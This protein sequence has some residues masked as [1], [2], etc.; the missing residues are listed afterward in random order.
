MKHTVYGYRTGNLTSAAGSVL[1]NISAEFFSKEN[2]QTFWFCNEN[3]SKESTIEDKFYHLGV[4]QIWY[5]TERYWG[6]SAND[7]CKW[8]VAGKANQRWTKICMFYKFRILRCSWEGPSKNLSCDSVWPLQ[9]KP[10]GL[11]RNRLLSRTL[12]NIHM[13]L[14]GFG[15]VMNLSNSKRN[16]LRMRNMI[17]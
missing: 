1:Q 13:K 16:I 11:Y 6:V 14:D 3:K 17:W 5:S 10:K 7:I 15:V 2:G 4:W 8:M 12:Y 9:M